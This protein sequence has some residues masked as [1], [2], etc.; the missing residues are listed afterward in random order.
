MPSGAKRTRPRLRTPQFLRGYWLKVRSWLAL[1]KWTNWPIRLLAILARVR[2][3]STPSTPKGFAAARRPAVPRQ[4]PA[5]LSILQLALTPGAAYGYRRLPAE[6][7]VF[8]RLM[9]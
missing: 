4:L 7:M 5:G 3:L 2:R 1:P 6:F 9:A 8:V